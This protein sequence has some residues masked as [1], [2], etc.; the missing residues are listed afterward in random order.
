MINLLPAVLIGGPPHAGKS[1]LFYSLT[2]ALHERG[3]V[4]HAVRACPDGEGNWFQE[5]H[6]E[7]G[8]ENIRLIFYSEKIWTDT[9]VKGISADVERRHLP[10]LVDM[11]GLPRESQLGILRN[12][13]HAVLLLKPEEETSM[14][15]WRELVALTDLSLL[16][17][18][19]SYQE[20]ESRLS[21]DAPV[22]RGTISGLHRGSIAQGPVFD[23]LVDRIA[24][25]FSSYSLDELEQAKLALA[26]VPFTINLDPLL[27]SID[28]GATSWLPA[29][30]PRLIAMLPAGQSLAVYGKGPNWL[31]G[32]LA[33]LVGQQPFYQFDPRIGWLSPP[34]LT[35]SEQPAPDEIAIELRPRE[36][37]GAVVL[38]VR[39]VNEYL[40]HLQAEQLPFPPV[41]AGG[42]L[43][44]DGKLPLWLYT[45]LVR[46]YQNTPVS[47][48]ACRQPQI[49]GAVVVMSRQGAPAIGDLIPIPNA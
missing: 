9:F 33:A 30:L 28:A 3:I 24:A 20:G 22:I 48:I 39:L 13:T 37:D 19:Y 7:V 18:I 47:W 10:F 46:L 25:L 15:S 12:C 41:P 26:P 1:V 8:P 42:G 49:K 44:L 17:E 16:A 27:H 29:M 40:D 34:V 31:Y 5:I 11:G 14:R 32:T 2:R 35:I 23:A 45:A 43:I 21:E 4:H 36:S 38:N 6:Q